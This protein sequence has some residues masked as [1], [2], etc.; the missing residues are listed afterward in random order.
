MVGSDV[1][2]VAADGEYPP[3]PLRLKPFAIEPAAV[4]NEQFAT[5]VT[6]ADYVTDAERFGWSY[7]FSGLLPDD[8]PPTQAVVGAEWW[9]RTEGARWDRPEGPRSTIDGRWGH[10][11]VHVSWNDARAYAAWAGG[12]L[13][14]EAE[15][16][17]AACSGG[18][19]RRFPW[20][21]AEPTDDGPFH[22]NIWQGSFPG[23]NTMADGWA[24]TAPVDAFVPNAAGLFNMVGNTWEWCAD[25]FRVRSL[26]RQ[27][28]LPPGSPV[29]RVTKGG[30]YLCHRSYCYRYRIT[31]RTGNS[32]DSTTGHLGFRVAYA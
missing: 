21:E 9:R 17:H 11:V 26:S 8:H 5:F 10:P 28:A 14:T 6:Q 16:E 22:C 15:W 7:V 19:R 1:P 29:R 2:M 4:T 3:R 30:S 13:P 31:G 12:R 32:P 25:A 20:G 24:G 27:A 23:H 18:A